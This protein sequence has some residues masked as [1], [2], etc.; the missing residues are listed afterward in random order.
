MYLY[1]QDTTLVC[2]IFAHDDPDGFDDDPEVEP[3]RPMFEII[4]IVL[5]TCF[6]FFQRLGFATPTIDLSPSGYAWFGLMAQ[7]ISFNQLAI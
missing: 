3:D 1:L 2:I 6:H 7:H 5:D 4:Q